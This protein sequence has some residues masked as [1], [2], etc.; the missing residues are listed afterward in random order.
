M[1]QKVNMKSSENESQNLKLQ[2]LYHANI[3]SGLSLGVR[4]ATMSVTPG[5]LAFIGNEMKIEPKG[6]S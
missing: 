5:H 6:T 3:I 2:I 4:A 1:D